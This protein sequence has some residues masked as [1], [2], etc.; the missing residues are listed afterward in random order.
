[1][2]SNKLDNNEELF[3]EIKNFLYICLFEGNI[4]DINLEIKN[5]FD[6]SN[7]DLKILKTVH[8]FLSDEVE[9]FFEILPN[10]L[11]NLSHYTNKNDELIKGHIKGNINWNKTIK[12]RY[13][14][15]SNDKSI[16]VCSP[17]SKYYDL[18][19]NQLL[20]FIL[21]KIIYLKKNYLSFLKENSKFDFEKILS[22][23]FYE[24]INYKYNQSKKAFNKVYFNEIS[25]IKKISSKHLQKSKNNR[26]KLYFYIFNVYKLYEKLFLKE[27]IGMLKQLIE[28]TI[29]KPLD[30]NKLFELYVFFKLIDYL[31]GE[32]RY[33]LLHINKNYGNSIT[34]TLP[35][36]SRIT[37]FYQFVPDDLYKISKYKHILDNYSLN[38]QI[39]S[40]DIIVKFEKE[41]LYRIFEIKNTEDENYI[42]D[43]IYKVIGYL[44]DF[45][46]SFNDDSLLMPDFPVVLVTWGGIEI[47]NENAFNKEIVILNKD[48]FNKYL[49]EGVLLK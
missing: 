20:K 4:S 16:F 34:T 18:E 37:I 36:Q 29:I 26:N 10:L 46:S 17:P 49:N 48:E 9:N 22:G 32:T 5:L 42:R 25:D 38:G 28:K 33:N 45:N 8:F 47:E 44:N 21:R 31:P 7:D 15:G 11:R 23:S 30:S 40:P 2:S 41:S 35:N 19:E 39:R 43:S 6:L 13:G 3:E 27:D 24:N 1:M 14:Q 12:I